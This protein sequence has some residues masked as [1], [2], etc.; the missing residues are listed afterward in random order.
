MHVTIGG[1]EIDLSSSGIRTLGELIDA[2]QSAASER[3]EIALGLVLNGEP[4]SP[5]QEASQRERELMPDDAIDFQ[6]QNASAVLT[7]A[8]E[9]TRDGLPA[10]EEKLGQV[11]VALQGG[12][13]QEA[14]SLFGECLTH[15]RQVIH[16]L[17]ATQAFLNYDPAE[18]KIEGRTIQN[19]NEELLTALQETKRAMEQGDLV[20]LSDLLEY[21]LAAKLREERTLLDQLISMVP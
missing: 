3:N 11:A 4:V 8:L 19:I 12:S 9:Q 5:D 21:E 16:L 6:V 17:Q 14:F 10:L 18:V 7:A 1:V 13:R 2:V 20:A 15:W